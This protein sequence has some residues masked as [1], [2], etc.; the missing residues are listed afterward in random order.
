MFKNCTKVQLN[1]Q[2]CVDTML[3]NDQNHVFKIQSNCE[4]YCIILT[5]NVRIEHN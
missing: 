4:R 2:P 1:Q 3:Q 5:Q